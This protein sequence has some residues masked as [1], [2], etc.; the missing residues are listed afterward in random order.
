MMSADHSRAEMSNFSLGLFFISEGHGASENG[1]AGTPN[2]HC[3]DQNC[4]VL[5][6]PGFC[7]TLEW[8]PEFFEG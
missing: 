8:K 3:L 7:V 1:I 4:S 2:P 5:S 6:L